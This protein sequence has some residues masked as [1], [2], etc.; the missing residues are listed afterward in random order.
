NRDIPKLDIAL[1]NAGLFRRSYSASPAGWE[2]T[3]QVN[4]LSTVL[5][6]L[7]LLPKLRSSASVSHPTHLTF[8]SSGSYRLVKPESLRTDGSILEL[9]N[10][11][12]Q[13]NGN[14]QYRCS[15]ALL[16]FAVKSIANLTRRDDGSLPVIVN[17]VCPGF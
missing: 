14:N 6:G 13:F 1:L 17:S 2:E 7:L 5:L 9:L 16:E 11:Q 8:V 4:T 3:L 12:D 10:Q 15:K